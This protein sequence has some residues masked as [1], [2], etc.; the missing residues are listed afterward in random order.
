V[1]AIAIDTM[2]KFPL[3]YSR[4]SQDVIIGSFYASYS[5]LDPA[6]ADISGFPK[7]PLP[8]WNINYNGLTKIEAIGDI[9][10]N[11]TLKHAYNGKYTVGRFDQN[12]RYSKGEAA[13]MG[14]DFT[15]QYQIAD[16]TISE[17]DHQKRMD[18]GHGIQTQPSAEIICRSVQPHRN[19][20]Q[21]VSVDRWLSG[22]RIDLAVSPKWAPHI[23]AQRFSI[24]F[25]RGRS[26][27]F[28]HDS[29]D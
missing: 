19:A 24:R 28:N 20:Q 27:Q 17:R 9:F 18:L 25:E 4:S 1:G 13:A 8:N 10:S 12:L 5:G 11:I 29:Q 26:R 23:L 7:I 21:R 22:N 14:V 15:P 2:T 6:S 3:G 16:V